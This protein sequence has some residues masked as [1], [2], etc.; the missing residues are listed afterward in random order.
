MHLQ[1]KV[2]SLLPSVYI[3]IQIMELLVQ[4]QIDGSIQNVHLTKTVSALWG[5]I[6]WLPLWLHTFKGDSREEAYQQWLSIIKYGLNNNATA[7]SF[8]RTIQYS[9]FS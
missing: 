7:L 1:H 5:A 3:F 6:F 4:G 2:N 8:T 9:I